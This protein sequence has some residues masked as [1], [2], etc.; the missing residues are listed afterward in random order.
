ME[1]TNRLIAVLDREDV[2]RAIREGVDEKF[3]AGYRLFQRAVSLM[4]IGLRREHPD[5]DAQEIT[6]LLRERL[7]A[8]RGQ[9]VAP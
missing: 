8:T 3:L 5:A 6:R 4:E 2:A 7:A 1:P 9:A